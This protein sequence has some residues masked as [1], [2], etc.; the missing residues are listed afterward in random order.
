LANNPNSTDGKT[1][2]MPPQSRII[3]PYYK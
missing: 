3:T 2:N 1:E